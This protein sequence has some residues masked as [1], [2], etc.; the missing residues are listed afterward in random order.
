MSRCP[1]T[2][3][4][5]FSLLQPRA[6]LIDFPAF[7]YAGSAY[8]A[9]PNR[10]LLGLEL[11]PYLQILG[12]GANYLCSMHGILPPEI[13]YGVEMTSKWNRVSWIDDFACNFPMSVTVR[14]NAVIYNI[15]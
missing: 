2:R 5:R 8:Q 11:A 12:D 13:I 1:W 4:G 7:R 6:M 10:S 9:E 15:R 3:A 14:W